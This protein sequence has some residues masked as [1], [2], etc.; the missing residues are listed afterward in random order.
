[1]KI[2]IKHIVI[3]SLFVLPGINSFG[4]YASNIG[5]FEV[6][7]IKGCA[8]LTV[9][10]NS[11]VSCPCDIRFGDGGTTVQDVFTHTYTQPGT[12][13]L[14]IDYQSLNPR[15]DVI[16][17]TVSEDLQPEFLIQSCSGNK[18]TAVI[19][20]TN[21][22]EYLID[23][24]N[25]GINEFT[26]PQGN[27]VP[28]HLYPS[29][30]NYTVSVKGR[31]F[32]SAENCTPALKSVNAISTITTTNINSIDVIDAN[33]IDIGY[34]PLSD[35]ALKLEMAT[36]STTAFQF[37][38][39]LDNSGVFNL[40]DN[41]IDATTNYY[42]FRIASFDPC[43][44]TSA[45]SETICSTALALSLQDALNALTWNTQPA[46]SNYSICKNGNCSISTTNAFYN[47]IDVICE[48]EYCYSITANYSNGATSTSFQKCG[49]SFS[50]AIPPPITNFISGVEQNEINLIWEPDPNFQPTEY[51][52]YSKQSDGS[53]K[54]I[55]SQ[56]AKTYTDFIGSNSTTHCYSIQYTDLCGNNSPSGKFICTLLLQATIL[57]DNSIQLNW[58]NYEGYE[59]GI[60]SYR[61]EKYDQNG[62]LINTF[63]S[64]TNQFLDQTDILLQQVSSYRIYAEP[65]D[66]QFN[67]SYSNL[68][69]VT[70][71]S[72]ISRPQAFTPNG[73]GLND[74][75]SFSGSFIQSFQLQV[76][77]RWGE[78][79]FVSDQINQG[80]DGT[81]RGKPLPS[82]S[83]AWT[84][85]L[86]DMAG[87][88]WDLTGI[89]ALI[90]N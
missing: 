67:E 76:F 19:T 10:I 40:I 21:Y 36:N 58:N 84:V 44:N 37:Y 39:N 80:W 1:M 34:Q 7:F 56:P 71:K 23:F 15:T 77:N 65:A 61:I 66:T 18:I 69:T 13:F 17:I 4:Q 14:E 20:D 27:T 49:I 41:S 48:T 24:E 43:N 33:T 3:L 73:D 86:V 28:S 54:L 60:S 47:D 85:T 75:F 53:E 87:R 55:S 81:Y 38:T 29:T 45:Y 88:S 16:Q 64:T 35:V 26:I 78:L 30:G 62:V 82:G 79:L 5:R 51:N 11:S 68:I 74:T 22:D 83:Y 46:I 72:L 2:A 42:C 52:L 63:F 32:N 12:Y 59:L 90:K 31:N 50:S 25:D 89:V 9:T 6:D 8:P 70:K 57:P